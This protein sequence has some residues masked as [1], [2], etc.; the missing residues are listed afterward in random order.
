MDFITTAGVTGIT[1]LCYLLG[2]ALR[3]SPAENRWIPL[4]CGLCGALLGLAGLR[5]MP[6]F[7]A[8]NWID[9]LAVGAA[10]GLAATGLD[11]LGKQLSE[12]L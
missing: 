4:C 10:S 12:T 2:L 7:P 1:T 5:W 6:E 3:L 8:G 9:A 11:Q